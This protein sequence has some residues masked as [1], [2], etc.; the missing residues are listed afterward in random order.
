MEKINLKVLNNYYNSIDFD[1][2]NSIP[3]VY[4][5]S[6]LNTYKKFII[7]NNF[8]EFKKKDNILELKRKKFTEIA[9]KSL[10]K[11]Y[12]K[13]LQI[14][15][16]PINE[17]TIKNEKIKKSIYEKNSILITSNVQ[18]KII[19][20]TRKLD[21][22]SYEDIYLK[23]KK[24]DFNTISNDKL[25]NK[26]NVKPKKK[27]VLNYCHFIKNTPREKINELPNLNSNL[28]T[29]ESL[30][31]N[32]FNNNGLTNKLGYQESSIR[33]GLR[34]RNSVLYLDNTKTSQDKDKYTTLEILS[35]VNN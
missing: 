25:N 11:K 23:K 29:I 19:S 12:E 4:N 1:K 21:P 9:K 33:Q 18:T 13:Y 5:D 30:D 2:I 24:Y 7:I 31:K 8:N 27:I 22:L 34:I 26:S 6:L 3:L 20:G 35:N 28:K 10:P 15:T 32:F 17:G 14:K 16:N